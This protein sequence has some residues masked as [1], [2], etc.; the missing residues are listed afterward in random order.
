MKA[1]M[2]DVATHAGVSIA[3]VSHVLN[4]TRYVADATR[5]RVMDS[6]QA[7]GY[8]PDSMARSFKMG[9]RNLIGFVV[10]DIAN[11]FW[12]VMIEEVEN[13]L[14]AQGYHLVIVNTK[15][16]EQREIEN[17]Q[18][19]SAGLVDGVIIASTLTDGAAIDSMLPSHFPLVFVDRT[20]ENC[21]HDSITISNYASIYSGIA[22]LIANGHS[23]IGY[24]PGLM[25]LSTTK[26]RLSAYRDAMRDHGMDVPDGLIQPGDSM[27]HSALKPMTSLLEQGCT[28]LVVSNNVMAGDV[29]AHL[30]R[31]GEERMRQIAVL[32]YRDSSGDVLCSAPAGLIDQPTAQ[33]AQLAAQ[34]I[35]RRIDE[36]ESQLRNVVLSSNLT[37]FGEP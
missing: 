27:S 28:A 35:L 33:M 29:I 12:A 22:H 21:P 20:L 8:V 26:E 17:L 24:I 3:T 13:T 10:P 14:A 23:K 4:N 19:L 9:R 37:L 5:Q 11:S 16:T 25:R 15:E 34:Q 32:G 2:R 30:G 31:R 7:L 18:L 36:P 6:I 1:N